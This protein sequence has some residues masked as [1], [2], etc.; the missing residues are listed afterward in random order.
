MRA[1]S[2]GTTKHVPIKR[3]ARAAA[4]A[5][6]K[7]LWFQVTRVHSLLSSRHARPE[8]VTLPFPPP[9]ALLRAA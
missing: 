1:S 8:R 2:A 3:K 7:K 6:A 5:R 9:C 4:E